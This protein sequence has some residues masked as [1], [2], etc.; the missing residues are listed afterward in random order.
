MDEKIMVE[1]TGAEFDEIL[2]YLVT[3]DNATVQ[4]A[5]LN[6]IRIALDNAY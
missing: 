6:A 4:T 1:F 2:S 5:I 3:L